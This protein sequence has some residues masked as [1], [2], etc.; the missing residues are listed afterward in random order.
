MIHT[1][2]ITI[3]SFNEGYMGEWMYPEGR[4]NISLRVDPHS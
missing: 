4:G 2:G 3:L 1:T